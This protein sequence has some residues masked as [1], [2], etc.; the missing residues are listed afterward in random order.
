[1]KATC[2][3]CGLEKKLRQSHFI[4]KFVT[5][6]IK[7]TSATGFLR[8]A[9]NPEKR[10]QDG[11]KKFFLCSDCEITFSKYESY[12]ANNFFYPHMN[13][14]Q[15]S[16]EYNSNLK[17]FIV[18]VNWRI[19]ADNIDNFEKNNPNWKSPLRHAESIWRDYLLGNKTDI[20]EYR[21]HLFFLDYIVNHND[22]LPNKFQFYTLR[23]IDG[24]IYYN[25]ELVH[26]Y[27]KL[28]GFII[29]ST[30][31]PTNPE[32]WINTEIF[33]SGKINVPQEISYPGFGDFLKDRARLIDT[34]KISRRE[35]TRITESILKN[36][37]RSM[38]SRSAEVFKAEEQREK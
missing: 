20:G 3:L 27:G 24:T 32:G 22:N 37:D 17:R 21:I 26:I 13:K 19:L 16:F 34:A 28:P 33:D 2:R 30:I 9:I 5:N 6:W 25:K 14:K 1:M 12:F 4:P 36:K 15:E 38:R 31:Y 29:F 8:Q 7:E 11:I 10:I 23:G 18:S 35:N